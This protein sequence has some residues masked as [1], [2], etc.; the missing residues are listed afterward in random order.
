LWRTTA[1]EIRKWLA[2]INN[3]PD[4]FLFPTRSGTRMARTAVTARLK[5]AV[6]RAATT[7]PQLAKR[8][9]SPHTIRK[10]FS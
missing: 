7:L 1:A 5:L 4:Q 10:A 6:Q 3:K 9:V 2:Q 8:R